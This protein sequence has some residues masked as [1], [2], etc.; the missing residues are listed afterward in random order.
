MNKRRKSKKQYIATVFAA[1]IIL[2]AGVIYAI[3]T[4]SNPQQNIPASGDTVILSV[5]FIDVGQADST[6][7]TLSTGETMLIDAG[8]AT[9][10]TPI[11]EE[12][13]ER[14]IDDIDILVATHPHSDHIG[15]MRSIVERYDIGRVLIPNMSSDSK[16]YTNMIN[17]LNS[18]DITIDEAYAGY[19]F[20]LGSAQCIVVSPNAE[21]DKDANNESIVI[22]L[23]Y[24][25][26]DFLFTG[27]MEEWAE[28]RVLDAHYYID[29]DV[30]KVAH[31]GSSTGSCEAFLAAVSPDYAVIS[32][33]LNNSYGHPHTDTLDR[34]YEI[35]ARIY[36]T[37]VLGD[38]LFVSDGKTLTITTGG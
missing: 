2:I 6:L 7:I 22:Y 18:K 8:E 4:L 34:L 9:E 15:G 21:D 32:C 33:G 13:D 35:G 19:S 24:G 12:L 14:N 1:I 20:F 27:D 26:T 3:D 29:A 5:Q 38:V 36:R 28:D 25:D 17:S 37:D 23:D 30:L 31:H 11:F 10:A 16:T